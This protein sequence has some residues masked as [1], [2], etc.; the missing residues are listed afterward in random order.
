MYIIIYISPL[1]LS[2]TPGIFYTG[3]YFYNH[4]HRLRLE[5]LLYCTGNIISRATATGCRYWS[6]LEFPTDTAF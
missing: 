4:A 1:D 3:T 5:K 6:F 2:P